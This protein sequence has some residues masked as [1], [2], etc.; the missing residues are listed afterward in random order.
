[1]V[2]KIA[3]MLFIL[4]SIVAVFAGN[5]YYQDKLD[6]QVKSARE[7][8]AIQ[9]QEEE[10]EKSNG[11][12]LEGPWSGKNWY[13]IG[14]SITADNKYQQVVQKELGFKTVQIDAEL[15]QSIRTMADRVTSENL[16]DM[17]LITIFGETYDFAHSNILGTINDDKNTLSY[18]GELKMVTEK[19]IA[20][21]EKDA[22]VVFITPMKRGEFNEEPS[23][24]EPNANGSKLEEYVN[25]MKEVA[26]LY[27]IPVI[28]LYKKSA[29]HEETFAQLTVDNLHPNDQGYEN[30]SMVMIEGLKVIEPD[31]VTAVPIIP[32][33]RDEVTREV[34]E[35]NKA[36]T[37]EK[38]AAKNEKKPQNSVNKE[39]AEP[40]S[41]P[42]TETRPDVKPEPKPESKPAPKPEPK[43]APEPEPKPAP[44]PKPE[45]EPEPKP[46]PKPEPVPKPEP[47]PK[48]KPEPEPEPEPKPEPK[49]APAPE[50]TPEM[51]PEEPVV[52]L[53]PIPESEVTP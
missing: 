28:D 12:E 37:E 8:L 42:K 3:F 40:R 39:K 15:D 43:P 6:N 53:A 32:A 2:K 47:E 31:T 38:A 52:E 25:A 26:G 5:K 36:D 19:I 41:K 11:P 48:P 27:H 51:E 4:F 24:T 29:F 49:P 44:E 13:S 16:R 21:K 7:N 34:E 1:M 18:Y 35:G 20:A 23:Y 33:Q 10:Q 30:I 17:D 22:V 46:E 45:P 50:P 14:S 9:Q